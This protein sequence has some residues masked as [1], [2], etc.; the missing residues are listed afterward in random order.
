MYSHIRFIVQNTS[1]LEKL[2]YVHISTLQPYTYLTLSL[3]Y[4]FTLVDQLEKNPFLNMLKNGDNKKRKGGTVCIFKIKLCKQ[5]HARQMNDKIDTRIFFL[6]DILSFFFTRSVTKWFSLKC[7]PFYNRKHTFILV[8]FWHTNWY[9]YISYYVLRKF[10]F[11]VKV[12]KLLTSIS[13]NRREMTTVCNYCDKRI[14]LKTKF[15]Y[16]QQPNSR[17]KY[18]PVINDLFIFLCGKYKFP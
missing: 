15:Y 17:S 16:Y 18:L 8:M 5:H 9:F 4:H 13:D 12:P 10:F 1:L 2:W 14:H 3:L 6:T 11:L 7:C